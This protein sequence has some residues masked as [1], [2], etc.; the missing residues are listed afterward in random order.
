MA[1]AMASACAH[2]RFAFGFDHDAGQ[3]FGAAVADD[4]AAGVLQLFFGG[5]DG[6]GYG[7]DGFEGALF[8]DFDVDD[9]L[10]EDLQVGGQL[11]DGFAGA[12]DEVE[13]DQG[14]EQ[15]VAGGGEMGQRMWP[16]CSPPRAALC[17]SICSRT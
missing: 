17:A 8:A 1:S 5:A 12:G 4:D 7:G 3:G 16:D 11:V 13:D 15:A 9:D 6:G 14:G 2:G 10:R